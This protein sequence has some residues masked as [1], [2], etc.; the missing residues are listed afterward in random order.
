M[1]KFYKQP[2]PNLKVIY[3]LRIDSKNLEKFLKVN[4]ELNQD[5][6]ISILAAY[7]DLAF[8]EENI[9]YSSLP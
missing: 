6:L 3:L 5:N 2:W 7:K 9:D 8:S 1:L 4:K